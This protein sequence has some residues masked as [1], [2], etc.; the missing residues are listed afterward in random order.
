MVPRRGM[1]PSTARNSG[2]VDPRRSTTDIPLPQSAALGCIFEW[3]NVIAVQRRWRY[4][5]T[6]LRRVNNMFA[7]SIAAGRNGPR[8]ALSLMTRPQLNFCRQFIC[9]FNPVTKDA[10]CQSINRAIGRLRR[11]PVGFTSVAVVCG[12]ITTPMYRWENG[13]RTMLAIHVNKLKSRQC[14]ALTSTIMTIGQY[15]ARHDR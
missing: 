15:I 11:T 2:Q 10:K 1:Q 4:T 14:A 8:L 5:F 12:A 13:K 6:A 3:R 7:I 9:G